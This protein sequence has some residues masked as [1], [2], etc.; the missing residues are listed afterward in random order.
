MED[1]TDE[2]RTAPIRPTTLD[3]QYRCLQCSNPLGRNERLYCKKCQGRYHQCDR[4]DCCDFIRTCEI[5]N[6]PQFS[7]QTTTTP[8][9]EGKRVK[10]NVPTMWSPKCNQCWKFLHISERHYCTKC[11]AKFHK[12]KLGVSCSITRDCISISI[13]SEKEGNH[14][15]PNVI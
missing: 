13:R 11:I 10:H 14:F 5:V 8:S 9:E 12:C 7:G 3:W 1:L 15:I 4:G 2:V 6:D